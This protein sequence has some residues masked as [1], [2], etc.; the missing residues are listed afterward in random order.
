MQPTESKAITLLR[1]PLMCAIIAVHCCLFSA[2]PWVNDLPVAGSVLYFIPNLLS[3]A[4]PVFFFISGLLFFHE[5]TF[6]V[7][8]YRKKISSR[9][10]SLL[11]PYILWI[12]IYFVIIASLQL[13]QPSLQLL[14]HKS[15][16]D[17]TVKDFF[18][19]FWNIQAITNLPTDQIGPLVGQFW[20]IQMLIIISVIS[21]VI[22]VGCKYLHLVFPILLFF[23]VCTDTVPDYHGQ[24]W[25]SLLY[26]SLG[27]VFSIHRLSLSRFLHQYIYI[28][29]AMLIISFLLSSATVSMAYINVLCII[30][31]VFHASIV[32]TER[33]FSIPSILTASSFFIFCFH[34]L[35]TASTTNIARMKLVPTDTPLSAISYYLLSIIISAILCIAIY[36]VFNHISPKLCSILSGNR[37]VQRQ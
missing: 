3:A 22:Y 20:Y 6:N 12:L 26:F 35:I 16:Y 14:L 8:Y 36:I 32:A 10:K 9:I 30:F 13:I 33:D 25:S 2:C 19:L 28:L 37:T 24:L 27:A 31:I 23:L 21:P 5:G 15:I 4:V 29:Y 34:R 7:F 17:L 11:L 1:F 18:Y